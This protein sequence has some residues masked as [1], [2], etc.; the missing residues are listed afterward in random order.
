MMIIIGHPEK[1]CFWDGENVRSVNKYQIMILTFHVSKPVLRFVHH[2]L[3]HSDP[4]KLV[5]MLFTQTHLLKKAVS[6]WIDVKTI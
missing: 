4:E 2:E 3:R 1:S 5:R 6:E